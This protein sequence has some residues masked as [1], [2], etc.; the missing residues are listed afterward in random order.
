M[1]LFLK[2]MVIKSFGNDRLKIQKGFHKQLVKDIKKIGTSTIHETTK[3]LIFFILVHH[4]TRLHLVLLY[5][6]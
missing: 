4:G 5:Q 2:M 1:Q 6:L 3:H